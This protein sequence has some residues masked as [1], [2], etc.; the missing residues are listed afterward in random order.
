MVVAVYAGK[1]GLDPDLNPAV[2]NTRVFKH[3]QTLDPLQKEA[4]NRRPL[5]LPAYHCNRNAGSPIR[6]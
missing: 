5:F 6:V 3:R 4:A 1:P 2:A